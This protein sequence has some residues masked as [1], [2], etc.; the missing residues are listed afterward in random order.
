MSWYTQNRPILRNS[1]IRK[2]VSMREK[3]MRYGQ[4]LKKKRVSDR[5]ELTLRDVAEELGVSVSFVSDVEQGRRKPFDEEKTQKLIDFL[6]FTEEDVA[7][8]YDLAAR[9]NSRIPRDLEDT[10][11][12]SEAGEMARYALRMTK[13]GVVNDD[14]W[15][16]FIRY[17]KT[18]EK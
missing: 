17:I 3:N 11:M 18:K 10:M 16:N 12:Y 5:R 1:N 15:K 13:K 9:E 8:M 4:F 14:D 7:L 2:K 6:E